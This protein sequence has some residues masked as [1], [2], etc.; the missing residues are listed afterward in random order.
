MAKILLMDDDPLIRDV[1]SEQ[2]TYLGYEVVSV[3]DGESAID[4]YK[5]SKEKGEPFDLIIMDLTVNSGMGGKEATKKIREFDKEVPIIVSTGYSEGEVVDNYEEYGFSGV[6]SKPFK[7]DEL[8]EKI[9]KSL[10]T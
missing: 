9:E 4:L 7:M 5:E 2:I 3:E 8:K 10:E 1:V 6:L